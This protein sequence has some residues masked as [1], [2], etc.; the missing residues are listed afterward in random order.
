[1]NNAALAIQSTGKGKCKLQGL[2]VPDGRVSTGG[3]GG[4]GGNI[5]RVV[6]GKGEGRHGRLAVAG[7]SR[8][9]SIAGSLVPVPFSYLALSCPPRKLDEAQ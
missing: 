1:M 8:P 7:G 2:C 9:R 6:E 3:G 5:P 4:G